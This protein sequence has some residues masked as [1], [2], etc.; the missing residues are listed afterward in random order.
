MIIVVQAQCTQDIVIL[1]NGFAIVAAV[2]LVPPVGV[3][4]ALATELG[5]RV[6]VAAILWLSASGTAR[7]GQR[8]AYHVRVSA[9]VVLDLGESRAEGG[10]DLLY[11]LRTAGEMGCDG[12]GR[13]AGRNNAPGEHAGSWLSTIRKRFG[14]V[15]YVVAQLEAIDCGGA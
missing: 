1:V 8:A 9:V 5:G 11:E 2:L 13:Q 12:M 15:A 14:R 6:D 3:G 7:R 4:V 10:A